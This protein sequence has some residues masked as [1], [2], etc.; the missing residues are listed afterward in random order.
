MEVRLGTSRDAASAATLV[1]IVAVSRRLQ[2]PVLDALRP[3]VPRGVACGREDPQRVACR[4]V[5]AADLSLPTLRDTIRRLRHADPGAG[6]VVLTSGEPA[7][8]AYLADF[9]AD[10]VVLSDR[11]AEVLPGVVQGLLS[12]DPLEALACSIE[13]SAP[14]RSQARTAILSS[15]RARPPYRTVKRLA[16]SMEMTEAALAKTWRDTIPHPALRLSDV[17]RLVAIERTAE[18]V[19]SGYEI[20]TAA[21]VIGW[22]I[23]RLRSAAHAYLGLPLKEASRKRGLA[24]AMLSDLARVLT[25]NETDEAPAR[26][27]PAK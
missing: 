21:R 15:L 3:V 18:L 5:I 2:A 14:V 4:I 12:R 13:A 10:A 7:N 23:R 24:A 16:L 17:L 6:L 19:A 11:V 1:E 8:L 9:V 26:I 20:G 25:G 22:N 27:R